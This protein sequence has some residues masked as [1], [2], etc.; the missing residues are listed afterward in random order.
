MRAI[1]ALLLAALPLGA[2]VTPALMDAIIH[3]ESSG[4]ASVRG[5][6]GLAVGLAQFHW[7]A[8]QD[9]TAFRRSKG[10]TIHPYS[11][12]SLPGPS[13][14]Y[15]HSWLTLNADRFRRATGREPSPGDL[16]AIHNLGFGGYEKRGFEILRCPSITRRKVQIITGRIDK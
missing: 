13:R 11:S 12:A 2:Q 10:L 9:T 8:W 5:D 7:G 3:I 6:S 16:Y 15:L 1:P 14:A 4:R